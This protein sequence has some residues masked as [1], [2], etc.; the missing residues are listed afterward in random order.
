MIA[1]NEKQSSLKI[2]K[3][4]TIDEK[5]IFQLNKIFDKGTVWNKTEGKKFISNKDSVLFLARLENVIIGFL[6]AYRLQRFDKRKAEILLY[7]IGVH[8]D[9]RR[10]GVGKALIEK[11]KK[12]AF[13][14]EA[15]EI[16]VL[17]NTS[18]I[19]AMTLYNSAGGKKD[20][21]GT[22]MFTYK[23]S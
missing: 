9:H 5:L 15:D 19:E 2:E 14:V 4:D 10:K 3:V 13:E 18:N 7:E 20:I 11:V 22:T 1:I 12:W 8:K 23:I 17:T 21:P 16:W 6:T